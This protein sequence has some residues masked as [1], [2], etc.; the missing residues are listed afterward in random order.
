[1]KAYNVVVE[2]ARGIIIDVVYARSRQEAFKRF[3][4]EHSIWDVYSC[5]IDEMK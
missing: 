4:E 5:V 3:V 1:M 2:V